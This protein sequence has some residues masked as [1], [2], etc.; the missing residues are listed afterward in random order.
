V[1]EG[2]AVQ[3]FIGFNSIGKLLKKLQIHAGTEAGTSVSALA[4]GRVYLNDRSS[5][6]TRC[7]LRR[8]SKVQRGWPIAK[9]FAD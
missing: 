9:S 6:V 3:V 8:F 5:M 7:D 1:D 4:P 2:L